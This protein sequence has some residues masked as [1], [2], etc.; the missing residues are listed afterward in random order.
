MNDRLI[1]NPFTYLYNYRHTNI[2]R[3]HSGTCVVDTMHMHTDCPCCVLLSV[4]IADLKK[5]QC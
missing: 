1:L 2:V 5:V 4:F 3:L